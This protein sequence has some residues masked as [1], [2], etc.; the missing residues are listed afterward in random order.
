MQ[1]YSHSRLSSYENCPLQYRLSYIDKID[2]EDEEGVEA[3]LGS[4]VH[5]TLEKL[6]RDHMHSKSNTVEELLM[7]YNDIWDKSWHDNVRIVRKEYT[8]DNYRKT[9]EKCIRDYYRRYTP[10]DDGHTLALEKQLNFE[11]DDYKITG[12]IDRI[13]HKGEGHYAIHDYKTAK[14]LPPKKSF[15][16]DRQLGL[17]QLGVEELWGDSEKVDLIWHYLV[18]NKEIISSRAP[19]HLEQLKA[20]VLAL[21]REIEKAEAEDRFP[22]KESGLCRWCLYADHCPNQ[23]HIFKTDAMLENE[24]LKEPGVKLVNRYAELT[25]EKKEYTSNMDAELEKLKEALIAYARKEGVELIRGTDSRV[26]ISPYAR[27]KL[28]GKN[29]ALRGEL[30][31]LIADSGEWVS[32]SDLNTYS[33][34]KALEE[35]VLKPDLKIKI[36]NLLSQEESYRLSI[37]RLKKD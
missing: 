32:Y 13:S 2:V 27:K 12:F 7:H 8:A 25:K 17:Y 3:F 26:K 20:D 5:E 9:G 28:P 18:H 11:L 30:E 34:I 35:D 37:S 36:E 6:Y 16:E 4:R 29:D 10:F 23:A 22:A 1:V 19:E 24:F 21:I 33:I 14:Y 15:D 31:K